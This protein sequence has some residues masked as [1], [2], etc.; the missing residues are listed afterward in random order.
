MPNQTL[1]APDHSDYDPVYADWALPSG[2][3][4]FGGN[5][6]LDMQLPGT[7]IIPSR[8][9]YIGFICAKSNA[10]IVFPN[11]AYLYA[12][13]WLNNG[14]DSY[15]IMG[16]N[17]FTLSGG[18]NGSPATTIDRKYRIFA[19]TD[20]ATSFLSTEL[21]F[22]T[23]PDDAAFSLGASVSLSWTRLGDVGIISYDVYR[24]TGSTY[25]LLQEVESGANTYVDNNVQEL[26][27]IGY[28]TATDDRSIALTTT[29]T[30]TTSS[31]LDTMAVDGVSA[32]WSNLSFPIPI[33]YDYDASDPPVSGDDGLQWLRIGVGGLTGDYAD[34]SLPTV[35]VTGGVTVTGDYDLFT[36]E[37][38]G[39]AVVLNDGV[40]DYRAEVDTFT[41]ENNIDI[42][43][44]VPDGTYSIYI[45][46]GAGPH[47][48]LIDCVSSSY[49]DGATF[50]NNDQDLTPPR[51]QFPRAAPNGSNQGGTG[52]SGE[53]GDGGGPHPGCPEEN[54]PI[55]VLFGNEVMEKRAADVRIGDVVTSGNIAPNRMVDVQRLWCPDIWLIE[56]ENGCALKASP[57][58]PV[59]RN[60]LDFFGTPMEALSVRGKVLT[61]VNG[62]C[63]QSRITTLGPTGKGG[64][65]MR[66]SC[67]P[68]RTYIAGS[69][70]NGT[71]GF[72]SHNK[73]FDP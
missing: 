16:S 15:W 26:N 14:V 3:A 69:C 67:S 9:Y 6:T 43:L 46:G 23:A 12:G 7:L 34:L 32:A 24:Q 40:S 30:L 45:I 28:P 64:W 22:P 8:K 1:K 41:D 63:G 35:T 54:E 4:R 31:V 70:E 66:F 36:L 27:V 51:P 18:I 59:H 25:T 47:C 11:T 52:G 29:R 2:T 55:S 71:G 13:F 62:V 72:I 50:S 61:F 68:G 38:E 53:P 58:H 19:R 20:R 56:T 37:M 60:S 33:P 42:D 49:A 39:L 17:P 57:S 73:R 44:P 48:I 21:D 5:A 65:T 10:Y